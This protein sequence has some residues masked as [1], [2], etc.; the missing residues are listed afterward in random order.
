[1]ITVDI[2]YAIEEPW[3]EMRPVLLG[4]V[5]VNL[6]SRDGFVC[7]SRNGDPWKR[8]DLYGTLSLPF[9]EGVYWQGKIVIGFGNWLCVVDPVDDEVSS[10][11]MDGYFGHL[12]P[13]DGF[14]LAAS[15]S[16]LHCFSPDGHRIWIAR[17]LGIDGVLVDDVDGDVIRG[18]GEWDPPG[19][20]LDFAVKLSTGEA[21]GLSESER[22]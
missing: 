10:H 1:M 17:N 9:I 15:A 4:D 19:G 8:L 13:Y 16:C 22:R 7:V 11:P 18:R 3:T 12:Y 21:L 2:V 14:L 5:P 20:W 6:S